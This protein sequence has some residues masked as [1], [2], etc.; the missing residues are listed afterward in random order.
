MSHCSRWVRPRTVIPT[1]EMDTM[2]P[3]LSTCISSL[4]PGLTLDASSSSSAGGKA[5]PQNGIRINGRLS[6]RGKQKCKE[7]FE[8]MDGKDG[9][10]NFEDFRAMKAFGNR[11]ID[12][13]VVHDPVQGCIFVVFCYSWLIPNF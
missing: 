8:Y 11:T 13:N 7:Y 5:G 2:R 12:N 4:R 9:M 10:V 6:F 1:S 3:N